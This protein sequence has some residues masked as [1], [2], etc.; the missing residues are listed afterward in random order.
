MTPN[1]QHDHSP[2][3]NDTHDADTPARAG[4]EQQTGRSSPATSPPPPSP[5]PPKG[6]GWVTLVV[7]ILT[8][9]VSVAIGVVAAQKLKTP[10]S[11]NELDITMRQ[12]KR[13]RSDRAI[14]QATYEQVA[15]VVEAEQQRIA[16]QAGDKPQYYNCGMHP[17]VILPNPGACLVCRMELTP[18]D[19][20]KF[21]GEIVIDPVITQSIGVRIE[22]VTT[23]PLVR[24]IRTV[25]TIDYDE[26]T[27][28]DINIKVPGWI[29]ELHV[30]Y[31]GA[32]IKAGDPLFDFYS[33]DLYV[34][35]EAYL[36]A[37]KDLNRLGSEA[38]P[39]IVSDALEMVD[40][41]RVQLEY[42]DVTPK[43]VEALASRE[44]ATKTM[45][46]FTRYDGVVIEK[47]ANEGMRVDQG[48][49]VYRIADLSKVWVMVTLYEY[50]LPFVQEGQNA[51]M[52]LPYIPGQRFEGKVIYIYPYLDKKTR[53]VNVRLEFENDAG[54]LK[55]GMFANIELANTLARERTL[56]PRSAIIDTG[57]RQVAFVSLGA[58][59]F[60]PRDVRTGVESDEGQVEILDGLRP[61]ELVVTSGQFLLDSEAKL[62]EA[63]AKMIRGDLASE[64]K[65]V[66]VVS[67]ESEINTLPPEVQ[68]ALGTALDAYFRVGGAL[69]S[70]SA[71]GIGAPAKEIA[72]QVDRLLETTIPDNEHFWHQ[73]D[74]VATVRGKALEMIDAPD[75]ET[76]RLL[77]ADLSVALSKL[78]RATG[79]PVTYGAEVQELHCPM[80]RQ[81]QGGSVWLQPKGDVRNPFF[82]AIM[83]ECFDE[84]NVITV[85]GSGSSSNE[86]SASDEPANEQSNA[87]ETAGGETGSGRP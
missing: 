48:M 54:L 23:G 46:V 8:V 45:T 28:R 60:E 64:Q 86:D 78:T 59:K 5:P 85:T 80:F 1:N 20:D 44:E 21:T 17:W 30:D 68:Q 76:A 19:P 73:H 82:G 2:A 16:D 63:L 58:G 41:A 7:F 13:L 51:V 35:Q 12:L 25:G 34:A 36:R 9:I 56:A 71:E 10:P 84:R 79:I 27:V 43:Q 75:L 49:R 55:P 14:D 83:L 81:G 39:N 15:Q 72:Q 6:P 70:D 50:Q 52:T 61:G 18:I 53:Q 42:Y 69:A 29:E 65:A 33:P 74:E 67:G 37:L 77:F 22:P 87:R 31:L 38:A 62:R 11:K 66:A 3:T 32:E 40:S 4:D 26:T 24:T 47:H 57:E